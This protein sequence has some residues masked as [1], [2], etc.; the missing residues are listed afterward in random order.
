M[1]VRRGYEYVPAV[2]LYFDEDMTTRRR[3]RVAGMLRGLMCAEAGWGT[4][5][6]GEMSSAIAPDVSTTGAM[7][8]MP[9]L[10]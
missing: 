6:I 1:P 3:N 10:L 9:S 2:N 5:P 4:M 8:A 7:P